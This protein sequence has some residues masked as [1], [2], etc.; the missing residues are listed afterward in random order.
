MARTE[1]KPSEILIAIVVVAIVGLVMGVFASNYVFMEWQKI[2]S[3]IY[4]YHLIFDYKAAYGDVPKVAQAIKVSMMLMVAVPF[5][6]V[7]GFLI[8]T[9]SN[10]S[11]TR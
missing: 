1:K 2:P 10:M 8:A 9:C 5:I 6:L 4:S 7:V 11:S 3:E